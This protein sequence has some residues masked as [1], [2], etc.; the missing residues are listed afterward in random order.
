MRLFK[1]K[2][3]DEFDS[4]VLHCAGDV[5]VSEYESHFTPGSSDWNDVFVLEYDVDVAF[6]SDVSSAS[7]YGGLVVLW[8]IELGRS[9]DVCSQD[10]FVILFCI[11][12]KSVLTPCL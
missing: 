3:E 9:T 12:R 7:E 5:S 4:V 2:G 11:F 10:E 6:E 1:C 8:G